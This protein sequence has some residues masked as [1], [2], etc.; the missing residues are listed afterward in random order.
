MGQIQSEISVVTGANDISLMAGP[1]WAS[2]VT[3]HSVVYT[4]KNVEAITVLLEVIIGG[5]AYILDEI[6]GF[7]AKNYVFPNIR[8]PNV[9]SFGDKAKFRFNTV[10][11]TAGDEDHSVAI[12]WSDFS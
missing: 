12:Q 2:S 11:V 8:T 1:S 9:L 4:R 5:R 7:V 10:G 3:L 6:A